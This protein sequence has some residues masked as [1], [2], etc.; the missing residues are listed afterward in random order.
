MVCGGHFDAVRAD[1]SDDLF[2][3]G[4]G[5]CVVRSNGVTMNGAFWYR[6]ASAFCKP[7]FSLPQMGCPPMGSKLS[8][9]ADMAWVMSRLVEPMSKM[10]IG[11]W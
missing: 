1:G 2:G 8:G 4:F 3:S 10:V 11:E 7:G 6:F 9:S 5:R